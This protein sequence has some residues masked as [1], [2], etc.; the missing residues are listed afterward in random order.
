MARRNDH[1]LGA[2]ADQ[3]DFGR[4]AYTIRWARSPCP[5]R[6]P[7]SRESA[8]LLTSPLAASLFRL[9]CASQPVIMPKATWADMRAP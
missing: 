5:P 1:K 2:L 7:A 3:R 4:Q 6:S 8:S 9:I